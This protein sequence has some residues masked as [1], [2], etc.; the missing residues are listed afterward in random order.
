MS[1]LLSITYASLLATLCGL[2]WSVSSTPSLSCAPGWVALY[3]CDTWSCD[4]ACLSEF[5]RKIPHHRWPSPQGFIILDLVFEYSTPDIR[6]RL[7]NLSPVVT[8]IWSRVAFIFATNPLH[9]YPQTILC[10][11]LISRIEETK[12][13]MP[14]GTLNSSV[15]CSRWRL[16]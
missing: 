4:Q 11:L 10:F 5:S 15:E 12:Y 1:S 14:C 3:R 8:V 16:C 7:W 9:Q 6:P 13:L 2:N